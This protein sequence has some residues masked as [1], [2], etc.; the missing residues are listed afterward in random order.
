MKIVNFVEYQLRHILQIYILDW[1][2]SCKYY[3]EFGL[4][5]P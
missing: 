2:Y 3:N 5:L 1:Y 4:G